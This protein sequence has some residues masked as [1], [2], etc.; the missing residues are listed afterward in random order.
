MD[1]L[2]DYHQIKMKPKYPM[3][4]SHLAS[5]SSS[6]S[7]RKYSPPSL[8]SQKY[9]YISVNFKTSPIVKYKKV[10]PIKALMIISDTI[11]LH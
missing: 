8:P 3:L 4:V 7:I 2:L 11:L 9:S 10:H 5:P 6:I 1:N